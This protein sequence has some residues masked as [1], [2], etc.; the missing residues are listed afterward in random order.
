MHLV[1]K[2]I[3]SSKLSS[4]ELSYVLTP[5]ECIGQLSRLRNSDD[6]LRNLPKELAQKISISAK[7]TTSALLAAI[8][9]E[10]GKGNW[11]SLSTVA[12]RSPLT[13]S[14]LQSFP[15]LKSLVDSVPASN[16]SKAFKAG[17]KQV[18]DDVALVRSYTHVP[19]EPSPDQKIVVEFAGQWS[20][21]AA[22]LMLGKTEAQK[23]KVTVGKAD[24]E[25]KHR[26]LAT[27]KD[28]DAEGKTLYIK[29]PC[30]D[31]PQPI[32]LKLAEDL[33]PVDKETQMDE[34]D[35]V[36]VPVVPVHKSDSGYV[37][38]DRGYIYVVWQSEV[39]REIQV[40]NDG[41]F[42]D[43]DLL[44]YQ[45]TKSSP[46]RSVDISLYDED[47][48]AFLSGEAFQLYQDGKK[49]FEGVL[50]EY[51]CA[52]VFGLTAEE[53][54]VVVAGWPNEGETYT[55]LLQTELSP[56]KAGSKTKREPLGVPLPHIWLPYKINGSVQSDVALFYSR[57]QLNTQQLNELKSGNNEKAVKV[58]LSDY[59]SAHNFDASSEPVISLPNLDT[60]A[61]SKSDYNIISQNEQ[62]VAAAV[63]N[64][65]SEGIVITYKSNPQCD[66]PDDFFQLAC[67]DETWS[68][69]IFLREAEFVDEYCKEVVFSGWLP[70]VKRVNLT[71]HC[72]SHN[73]DK[74]V[75][76]SVI[77]QDIELTELL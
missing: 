67:V 43:V 20:S 62:G 14:Q 17:Y 6:I 24:T 29:I 72:R 7:K 21:N 53:V 1:C 11:V 16:E 27:F 45:S 15:R 48:E 31:Q 49:V 47:S 51:A 9:I 3:P 56:F 26:S 77:Y 22:C 36:L 2:F 55:E 63:V 61:P 54:E 33:Q 64:S 74:T 4:N 35:N 38:I 8:R 52:R 46:Q 73:S 65:P 75:L 34:W 32:L 19:S 70:E 76:M 42:S 28:L 5:D 44:L 18:T 69:K 68:Q 37:S 39:W 57:T 13:D 23:E 41:R 40:Q 25:N 50:D 30:S 71:R 66:Q 60:Q 10:L 59:S 12:R 58:N